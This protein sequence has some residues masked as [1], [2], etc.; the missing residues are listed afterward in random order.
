[1]LV[2]HPDSPPVSFS[3]SS[4]HTIRGYTMEMLYCGHQTKL[5]A[6]IVAATVLF[7][8]S[9]ALA[10]GASC[11]C[12]IDSVYYDADVLPQYSASTWIPYVTPATA[13]VDV[14]DGVLHINST[15]NVYDTASFRNNW[16]ADNAEGATVEARMKLNTFV[17][18]TALGGAAIWVE[19][20]LYADVLII[21]PHGI[22]LYSD[23]SLYYAFPTT[24]T[25]HSYRITTKDDDIM[26][27]VDGLLVIDGTGMFGGNWWT[28]RK[29]VAFGDY[30]HGAGADSSW[31][32]VRYSRCVWD[33]DYGADTLPSHASP[34]WTPVQSAA[35]VVEAASGALQIDTLGSNNFTAYYTRSWNMSLQQGA[36]VEARMRLASYAGNANLGGAAIWIESSTSADVLL[37]RPTGIKLYKSGE[38]FNFD[39]TDDYHRYC[40][41]VQGESINVYIDDATSPVIT[42]EFLP[43]SWARNWVA[44]GD[45][46]Y[47]AGSSSLW[48]Y[49]RYSF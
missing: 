4:E 18:N 31:D 41:D 25:F 37:I 9:N 7:G 27:Y 6:T 43:R 36:S 11:A 33:V 17:G 2:C 3:K 40:V 29:M 34:A 24:D 46:S 19:D 44:F 48:D 38:Q 8:S 12:S 49:V 39:T 28:T 47:G 5:S 10:A 1:M 14:F 26:V 13:V 15:T 23:P 45:G 42:G 30:S 21:E 20:N 35:S 16:D 22:H 32:Y